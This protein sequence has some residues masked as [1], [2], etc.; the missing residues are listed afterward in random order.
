VRTWKKPGENGVL[1]SGI[2]DCPKNESRGV[3]SPIRLMETLRPAQ[4]LAALVDL[5]RVGARHQVAM[6]NGGTVQEVGA[7]GEVVVR[8][9]AYVACVVDRR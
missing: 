9:G 4:S 2:G 1:P 6:G 7:S 8:R 5:I 3:R